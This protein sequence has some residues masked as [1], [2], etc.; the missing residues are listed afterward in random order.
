VALDAALEEQGRQVELVLCIDADPDVIV[1]RVAKRIVCSGCSGVFNLLS[2]PPRQ[3]GICDHCGGALVRRSDEA[4]AV[5]RQ[6][7]ESYA[8]HTVPVV[9]YYRRRGLVAVVDGGQDI[10]TVD[11]AVDAVMAASTAGRSSDVST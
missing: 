10:A 3:A 9:E 4:E 8:R 7:L 5:V 2:D 6:R 1:A 11:A